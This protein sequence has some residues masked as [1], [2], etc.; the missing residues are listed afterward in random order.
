M[1]SRGHH[2]EILLHKQS[3]DLNQNATVNAPRHCFNGNWSKNICP[4]H[5][6]VEC[7]NSDQIKWLSWSVSI[8]Q[9]PSPHCL[10]PPNPI[11][12]LSKVLTNSHRFQLIPFLSGPAQGI[13]SVHGGEGGLRL[14]RTSAGG[15]QESASSTGMVTAKL[16]CSSGRDSVQEDR[17]SAQAQLQRRG[18]T[19]ARALS[20]ATSHPSSG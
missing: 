11:F 6:F 12:F 10:I 5:F 20:E 9:P 14:G 15:G 3:L 16:R 13:K 2:Q 18:V 8:L 7:R 19:L 17:P 4:N 1:L